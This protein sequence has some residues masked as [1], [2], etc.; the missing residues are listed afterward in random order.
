MKPYERRALNAY[1]YYTLATWVPHLLT[2]KDTSRSYDNIRIA[3]A[4]A[5]NE[6]KYRITMV[7]ENGKRTVIQ[8]FTVG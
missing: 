6:G 7:T 1:P 3:K 8:T 5:K 4:A 2:Y